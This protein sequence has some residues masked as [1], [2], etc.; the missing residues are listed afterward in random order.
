ML[1]WLWCRKAATAPIRPQAWESPYAMGAALKKA[2]R[3][4][5]KRKINILKYSMVLL[6]LKVP[7]LERQTE[8]FIKQQET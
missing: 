6:F 8:G 7:F 4:K 2:K 5:R 3:Q 1:L